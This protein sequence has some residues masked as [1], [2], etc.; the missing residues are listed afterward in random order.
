MSPVSV[1][2]CNSVSSG[3][4]SCRLASS[5]R[6]CAEAS[7]MLA[8]TSMRSP[9]C[10]ISKPILSEVWLARTSTSLF[11]QDFTS[12][13]P[14]AT[15]WITTTGRLL[16]AKCFSRCCA[17]AAAGRL[18]HRKAAAPSTG[19]KLHFGNLHVS[20]I[21]FLLIQ[22]LSS[23]GEGNLPNGLGNIRI[24]FQADIRSLPQLQDPSS[25]D[26]QAHSCSRQSAAT[27][28][29]VEAKPPGRA[30][31]VSR[32]DGRLDNSF[33]FKLSLDG[34]PHASGWC[35]FGEQFLGDRNNG[36]EIANKFLAMAASGHMRP[37]CFRQRRQ[38]F[39]LDYD[40]HVLTQHKSCTPRE[41]AL[42]ACPVRLLSNRFSANPRCSAVKSLTHPELH[43]L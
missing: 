18:E 13:R 21:D 2:S 43:S 32:N 36:R 33:E 17:A 24:S 22:H 29:L 3:T 14:L 8:V 25:D 41:L 38:T 34:K 30:L 6:D 7:R 26:Q 40:F 15:L 42:D 4:V 1:L 27:K 20:E 31:A 23:L 39:L 10:S 19:S 28:Q 5:S 16:T 9:A 11:F 35:D 37:C 12:M